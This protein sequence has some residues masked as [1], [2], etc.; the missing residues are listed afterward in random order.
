MVAETTTG[1][2]VRFVRLYL[3]ENRMDVVVESEGVPALIEHRWYTRTPRDL[4]EGDW[5]AMTM[6][7]VRLQK[8]Q[9]GKKAK[10]RLMPWDM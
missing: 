7:E 9:A 10:G 1:P 8:G 4:P 6:K 5:Y 3:G 2:R